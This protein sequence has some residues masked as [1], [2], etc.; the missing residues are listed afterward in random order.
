MSSQHW[1][2]VDVRCFTCAKEAKIRIDQFN[3]R[4]KTWECRSCAYKGKKLSVQNPSARHDSI[5]KGAWSSYYK[6]KR[7]CTS[8]HY[9][10]YTNIEF[11]FDSFDEFY[12]ELGPRTEG[13]SLD[14][15]DNFGHYEPG[16]VRWA[17]H[18]EQCNNRRARGSVSR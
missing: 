1:N 2:Y 14:R 17:T 4:G 9:G 15:I 12:A 18:Q 6:A 11:R 10:Y 5:K 8:G 16:N 13:M 7:R 3:R